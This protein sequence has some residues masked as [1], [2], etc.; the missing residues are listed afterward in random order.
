MKGTPK[1]PEPKVDPELEPVPEPFIMFQLNLKEHDPMMLV[2]LVFRASFVMGFDEIGAEDQ[3]MPRFRNAAE[4]PQGSDRKPCE[5]LKQNI[6]RNTAD[7]WLE[8]GFGAGFDFLFSG[9][10]SHF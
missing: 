6:I 5:Y 8:L 10:F 4:P 1:L 7:N 2:F 3:G 9:S